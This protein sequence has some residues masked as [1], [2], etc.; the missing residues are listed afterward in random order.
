[1]SYDNR[2]RTIRKTDIIQGTER[3]NDHTQM[4]NVFATKGCYYCKQKRKDKPS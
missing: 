2:E 1:M 4:K 3:L